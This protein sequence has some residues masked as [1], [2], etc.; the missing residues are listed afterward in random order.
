[1]P[2]NERRVA[3]VT[4]SGRGI[5]AVIAAYLGTAGYDVAL[6]YWH[7][8]SRARAIAATIRAHGGEASCFYADLSEL[9]TPSQLVAEVLDHFGRLDAVVNNAATVVG[10]AFQ[11]VTAEDLDHAYHLNYRAPFVISQAAA[12]WM[13]GHGVQ[14]AMVQI[15]SVHQERVTDWDSVYG[16]MKAALARATESMAYELAP[17]GIRVNAVAPGRILTPEQAGLADPKREALVA[18]G[19]PLGVSGQADDVA[20]AVGWLL[21]PAAHY[22]TGITLRVD[23]GLNLPMHRALIGQQLEFI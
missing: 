12:A 2:Q 13:I 18:E 21:S 15:T 10:R 4:G 19:I 14:G 17:Y 3:L 7:G 5:G 6:H 8:E 20:R 22:V 9:D 16:S 11:D 1:M 23:G